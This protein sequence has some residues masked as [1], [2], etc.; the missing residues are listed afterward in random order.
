MPEGLPKG[1]YNYV[2]T[3]SLN[4]HSIGSDDGRFN[5]GDF[6]I[7]LS[8]PRMRSDI[9]RML[10][11]RTG[12]KFYTPD[13]VSNIL[14]DIYASQRF[15]P[16]EIVNTRDFELWNSWPLL[17]LAIVC[18]GAEWFIRKRLGML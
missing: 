18:F 12:G 1:D 7:E 15:Q 17:V 9:L 3:A 13:N 8:E 11:Q 16:K 5:V 14:K 4:G 2:G 6:N 10:A